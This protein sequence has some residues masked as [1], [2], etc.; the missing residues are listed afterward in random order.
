MPTAAIVLVGGVGAVL[1]SSVR[2]NEERA[3]LIRQRLAVTARFQALRIRLQQDLLEEVGGVVS[4]HS[5]L[6]E[7]VRDQLAEAEN[8]R[9]L[10]DPQTNARLDDLSILLGS[11]GA[12]PGS[13]LLVAVSLLQEIHDGEVAAQQTLLEQIRR[14]GRREESAVLGAFVGLLMLA[15][16]GAWLA[17]TRVL[18]P[19]EELRALL[20]RLGDRDFARIEMSGVDPLLEPL[21]VNYNDLVT[22]LAALEE[23]HRTHARTLERD[24]YTAT[25]TLLEQH[26]S[27]AAAERL[28]AAGV[29][30]SAV[31]HE[32]RNPLAG[33]LMALENLRRDIVDAP[34]GERIGPVIREV[35]R[36]TRLLN[37]YLAETRHEPE[38]AVPTDL[39]ELADDLIALLRYQVAES[40]ELAADIPGGLVCDV[41]RDRIRQML[42]N[43][44]LNSIEALGPHPGHVWVRACST[45]GQVEIA[46]ADDGPGFSEDMLAHGVRAFVTGKP[47][48]TGL[49]LAM[50]ERTASDLG[51]RVSLGN[52]EQGGALV[53]ITFPCR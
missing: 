7:D 19:I 41:P 48:G 4:T 6:V 5:Y 16:V 38:E 3:E 50:V 52:A 23:E 33:V 32:L 49:G 44:V 20:S 8:L 12:V 53:R 40:V 21:F 24:V 13:T 43:L 10:L 45:D 14:D 39:R 31:A 46:V 51:G 17:R 22:R 28:A 27:L 25:R 11:T 37:Q 30:A 42:L 18:K 47:V 29:T 1:W 2:R 35:Q 34:L 15:L 9:G 26:R 36:V